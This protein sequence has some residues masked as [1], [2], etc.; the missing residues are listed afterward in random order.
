MRN[1]LHDPGWLL[2]VTGVTLVLVI[3]FAFYLNVL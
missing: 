1:P 3:I 2:L